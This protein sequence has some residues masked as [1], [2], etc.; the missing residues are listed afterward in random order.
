MKIHIEFEKGNTKSTVETQATTVQELLSQLQ[1]N[2][3]T[4]LVA[5]NNE[6]LT[7]DIELKSEDSLQI[8]SVISGG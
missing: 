4:V 1:I 6:I 5:R 8:L 3:E 7:E 2:K